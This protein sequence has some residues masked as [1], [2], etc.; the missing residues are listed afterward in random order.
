[1]A[2]LLRIQ[3]A[4]IAAL[5]V[6]SSQGSQPLGHDKQRE[7]LL[8]GA[9]DA[10]CTATIKGSTARAV[11]GALACSPS[12]LAALCQLIQVGPQAPKH[13]HHTGR[14]HLAPAVG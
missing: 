8:E 5:E 6:V 7:E 4:A 12:A 9:L 10:L 1:M 13:G 3:L 11:L 2:A 14:H